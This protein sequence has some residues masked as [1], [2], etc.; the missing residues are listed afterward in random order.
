MNSEVFLGRQQIV[1]AEREIFGYELLYRGHDQ[2]IPIDD[3]DAATRCVMERVFLQWGMEHVVGDRFGLMNASASLIV[4]GLHEAMPPEAM[5][6]EVRE[7]SPFDAT[8]VDALRQARRN[9]YHFALDNVSRLC[10]LEHSELLPLAS[11]VKIELTTAHHAE[12]GRLIMVARER[13][14]GVLVVA[15]KVESHDEF[16][17]CV[18]RGFDLFQGFHLGEPEV[19]RRPARH[20]GRRAATALHATLGD[21]IDVAQAEAIVASDPSLTFRLLAAVNANAFGLDRRVTTLDEAIAL[22]GVSKLRCLA[23][24]LA[25]SIDAVDDHTDDRHTDQV[26][27]GTAR[28][29]MVA[30]LLADTDLVR[31][32]VTA[33]LLSVVDRLYDAPLAE[34]LDELPMSDVA[35]R[36]LLHGAGRVGEALDVVRAC[37]Q[38]DRASL[39]Q[40]APG[41]RDELMAM[42]DHATDVARRRHATAA[43]TPVVAAIAEAPEP[44]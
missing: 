12:I 19:L 18:D 41:R 16:N 35:I 32:G 9:G 26:I 44:A 25:S 42:H 24:L 4:N 36:A 2:R 27:R 13:S 10:D 7:P 29:D 5:I 38:G 15:E 8:T 20:A 14:P 28:A 34:L 31:F 1:D 17:R 22:L 6:I 33:G 30:V 40:L 11:I 37:E 43:T 3:P 39:D 23:D 21:E